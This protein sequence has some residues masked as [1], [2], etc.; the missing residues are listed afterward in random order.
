MGDVN[1]YHSVKLQQIEYARAY[2]CY[3]FQEKE[4]G[5][6]APSLCTLGPIFNR[7]ILEL[8]LLVLRFCSIRST[9]SHT[10]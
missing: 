5:D 6:L 1:L 10:I 9:Q 7:K 3:S 2:E 4:L 8:A